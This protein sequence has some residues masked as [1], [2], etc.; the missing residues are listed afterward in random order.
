MAALPTHISRYEIKSLIGRGGMG[1]LYLAFDPNTNRLVALKLLNA[2]LDSNELRERFSREARALAALNHTN[3]VN[4]YDTGE[5]EDSPFIVMEYVRGETLAELIK[6]RATLTVSQKL[7]LMAELCAGLAQ[8]HEAGIIHRDIKPANLMVDQQG[9]LKILDFG[10][11]RVAEAG[12]TRVGLPLTQVNMLIGTPGYMS[13]EQIEGGEVDHRSDIFAVGAV[14]YELLAY[15]EAFSGANTRQIESR[16]LR[17]QPAPLAS[18]VPGLDPEIDEIVLRALKRDPNKRYQDAATFE[19]ALERLRARMGPDASAPPR[20]PSPPPPPQRASGKSRDARAEAAYQRAL[21]AHT[22][23]ATEAARRF[24][25]E[26][27]AEDPSHAAARAL[28]A[29]LQPRAPLVQTAHT[30]SPLDSVTQ[31]AVE[32]AAGGARTRTSGSTNASPSTSASAPTIIISPASTV[33]R[34]PG[35]WN[36]YQRLWSRDGPQRKRDKSGTRPADKPSAKRGGSP[37]KWHED[38]WTRHRRP[39]MAAALLVIL[40]GI[41]GVAALLMFLGSWLL[42]P[43]GQLLTITKPDGGT[44]SAAGIRCGTRGADCSV[45]RPNGDT[46]ELTTEADA[47]FTFVGYTGDCAPGG[48]TIM[49]AARTCGAT[50][51]QGA[52][53][54]AVATQVLTI[55]PVPTGGTIEGVDIFCGTKGSVCSANHPEGVPVELHPTADAEFTFIQFGGDC[56]P[57]GRTQMSGPRTCSATFSPTAE[58]SKPPV[59]PPSIARGRSTPP[60]VTTPPPNGRG[61]G[62]PPPTADASRASGPGAS[63]PAPSVPGTAAPTGQTGAA[64]TG[65]PGPTPPPTLRGGIVPPPT[66]APVPIVPPPT[67]DEFAKGQ[68]QDVLKAFCAGYEALDPKAVKVVQPKADLEALQRQM[69][70]YKSA[71]CKFAEPKFPAL[72]AKVGSAKVE[73]DLKRGYVMVGSAKP[74]NYEQIATLTLVRPGARTPWVIDTVTYKPKPK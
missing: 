72:D 22:G 66:V 62:L 69:K 40:V 68:I 56:A 34:A 65:Q 64:A 37:R 21:T 12:K 41:V 19:K 9:R 30:A 13:P 67:D 39:A 15:D 27:L 48:R 63:G 10:I 45:N 46:I 71:E 36:R 73:A 3:I 28:L 57:L 51:V 17:G 7:K 18:V 31:T 54:T 35:F 52:S 20:R 26:A 60:P 43:S 29:R 47:G 50:F 70:Q 59:L 32:T 74:E 16:V 1:D 49:T 44:I 24:A 25:V 33:A 42:R 2:T 6:R 53:P 14:C 58:V 8:A 11:A 61:P 23:G 5:F 38:V 4:I 55:Y